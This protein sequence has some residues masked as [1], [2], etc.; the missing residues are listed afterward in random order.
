MSSVTAADVVTFTTG[1]ASN[2]A[3][4]VVGNLLTDAIKYLIG[5]DAVDL[6]T[7][8]IEAIANR[9]GQAITANDIRKAAASQKAALD[10]LDNYTSERTKD[11]ALLDQATTQGYSVIEELQSLGMAGS[12]AFLVAVNGQILTLRERYDARN[13]EGEKENARKR[14]H[15]WR[16]YAAELGVKWVEWGQS[17]VFFRPPLSPS[18]YLPGALPKD[19]PRI[20]DGT[21]STFVVDGFPFQ[22]F[23][24]VPFG[25]FHWI[26]WSVNNGLRGPFDSR[27]AAEAD[28]NAV[29]DDY[30]HNQTP[31][32]PITQTEPKWG[33]IL[34]QIPDW[35]PPG[36]GP[37]PPAAGA[38][39]PLGDAD[40]DQPQSSDCRILIG[41]KCSCQ[42]PA[43]ISLLFRDLTVYGLLKPR[44]IHI[45]TNRFILSTRP[46]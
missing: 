14:L 25:K 12:L 41:G 11:P 34:K 29:F 3:F 21:V 19:G 46:N 28:W 15:D 36:R 17:N 9:I 35:K 31:Y 4:G 24:E 23:A 27:N 6:T 37:G 26:N 42:V 38:R 43:L 22:Y 7:G 45:P 13:D 39:R 16:T 10:I 2:V 30:L 33:D 20:L 44:S 32:G 1:A 5:N 18:A 8:T 40:S